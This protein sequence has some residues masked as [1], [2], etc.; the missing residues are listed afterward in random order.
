[1]LA[2]D[3]LQLQSSLKQQATALKEKEFNLH[4]SNFMTVGT[5]AAVL[6]A[7]DCTM[8]IEFSPPPDEAWGNPLIPRLLKT[9]YYATIVGA[10]GA[11]MIVVA[12]TTALSVC[13]AGLA[14]RGP[15]GSMMTATEGLYEERNRVFGSFALGL[16]LTVGSILVSVWI[17]FRWET[18]CVCWIVALTTCRQIYMNYK[19]IALRFDFD[20]SETVDFTD[21][22]QGPADIVAVPAMNT[23]RKKRSPSNTVV[24]KGGAIPTKSKQTKD[25]GVADDKQQQRGEQSSDDDDLEMQSQEREMLIANGKPSYSSRLWSVKHRKGSVTSSPE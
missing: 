8:F 13:G 18:A 16:T 12:H 6:A 19:R 17:L 22:F 24:A 10:F 7:L 3:K 25:K 11:N 2:A 14:L 15:D 1:M 4:H 20:E 21:I 5:Q 9:G 23:L